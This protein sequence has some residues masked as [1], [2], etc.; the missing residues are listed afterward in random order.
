GVSVQTL[1][2]DCQ[3]LTT[4]FSLVRTAIAAG[5]PSDPGSPIWAG[6]DRT[7]SLFPDTTSRRAVLLVTDGE[8]DTAEGLLRQT[9]SASRDIGRC[10]Y[11]TPVTPVAMT[12]DG[13]VR[14]IE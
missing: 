7:V 5:L 6:L 1:A 10:R 14:H 2:A 3:P 9:N 8:N 13:A 4:D 11:A 12:A